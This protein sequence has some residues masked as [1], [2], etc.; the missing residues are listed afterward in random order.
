[1]ASDDPISVSR[2][3]PAGTV[4]FLFT[5]IEGSTALL[6]D[7]GAEA[8]ADALAEHRQ[9]VRDACAPHGGIEVGT[10]GDSFFIAFPTAEG[11]LAAASAITT[12]LASGPIRVRIGMHTGTPLVTD[13]GYVGPDVHRAARIAASGHGGQV[14]VSSATAALVGH[15]GLRDLGEHRFKDLLAPERVYQLGEEEFP[16]LKS[17]HRTNLPVPATPFVGRRRELPGGGRPAEP[18][19]RSPGHAHRPGRHRKDPACAPSRRRG[20]GSI[21]T[22]ESRGFRSPRCAIPRCYSRRLLKRST[23]RKNRGGRS[24]RRW[25]RRL[26]ANGHCSY[27]TTSS[28]SSLMRPPRS[29]PCAISTA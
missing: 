28:I 8:Y 4:T 14:L 24:P 2:D 23:S 13:E 1:M 6:H 22:A 29:S 5:D 21:I 17:L 15:D 9:V 19:E 16:A 18:Q 26:P 20:L 11:A 10:E 7:L 12:G 27:S 25:P 3:L